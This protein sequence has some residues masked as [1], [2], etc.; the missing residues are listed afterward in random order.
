MTEFLQLGF[1]SHMTE[2]LHQ[3]SLGFTSHMTEFLVI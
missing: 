1:T 2:F 3:A